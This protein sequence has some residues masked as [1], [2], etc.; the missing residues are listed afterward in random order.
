MVCDGRQQSYRQEEEE[1]LWTEETRKVQ[2][3]FLA[4]EEEGKDET[5]REDHSKL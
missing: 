2:K 5:A 1:E 4:G 3:T